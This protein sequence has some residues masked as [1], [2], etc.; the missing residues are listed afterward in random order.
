MDEDRDISLIRRNTPQEK[1]N[2]DEKDDAAVFILKKTND[3]KAK[4][5]VDNHNRYAYDG[6]G[7]DDDDLDSDDGNDDD[8]PMLELESEKCLNPHLN[9]HLKPSLSSSVADTLICLSLFFLI[10][11]S[12]VHLFSMRNPSWES[13]VDN[14]KRCI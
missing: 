11:L 14:H 9:P 4:F 10:I 7:E 2:M 13:L 1:N 6:I 8:I 5:S 12:L 3:E